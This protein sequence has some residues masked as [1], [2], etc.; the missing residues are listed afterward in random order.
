MVGWDEMVDWLRWLV[1]CQWLGWYG[2]K[3]SHISLINHLSLF[4]FYP[5]I[6][7]S[8]FWC[9]LFSMLKKTIITNH[10]INNH[11]SFLIIKRYINLFIVKVEKNLRLKWSMC[12]KWR[13]VLVGLFRFFETP[14]FLVLIIS[15]ITSSTLNSL[16]QLSILISFS[17][18]L[19]S[20]LNFYYFSYKIQ[21]LTK[22]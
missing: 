12:K 20:C 15:L 7:L 8:F 11:H 13:S 6:S 18:P 19:L 22:F 5:L 10:Q 2:N 16:Y 3:S 21:V 17:R 9:F 14:I 4:S 1:G